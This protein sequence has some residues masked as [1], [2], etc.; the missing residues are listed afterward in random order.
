M[1]DEHVLDLP[2]DLSDRVEGGARFWKII[3]IS[4]PRISRIWRSA[5]CLR[6][7]PSNT[8][9]PARI[10]PPASSMRIRA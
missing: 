9:S 3:E 5:A 8:I 6:S 7:R 10:S 4:R 1:A 2:A